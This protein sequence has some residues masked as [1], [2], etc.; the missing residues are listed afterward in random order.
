M[1]Q[2]YKISKRKS[3][4]VK[5]NNDKKKETKSKGINPK[6]GGLQRLITQKLLQVFKEKGV[7]KYEV[8]I[9][10]ERRHNHF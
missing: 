1:F 6:F 7:Q 4:E 10:R 9:C 3:L 5:A 8:T 2:N